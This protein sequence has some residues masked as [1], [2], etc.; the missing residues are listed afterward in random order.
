MNAAVI[1]PEKL[2]RELNELWAQLAAEKEGAEHDVL[3]SCSMTLIVLT[4]GG[5]D[6][7]EVMET[8]GGL[9]P[10]YPCRLILIDIAPGQ[11]RF[12]QSSVRAHCWRPFSGQRQV[13][14][15]QISL[16]AAGGALGDLPPVVRALIVPDLPVVLWCLQMD[17]LAAGEVTP[18]IRTAGK[19][20]VDSHG[21]QPAAAFEQIERLQS[22][23]ILLGDLAWARLTRWRELL[24]QTLACVAASGPVSVDKATVVYAEPEPGTEAFYLAGWLKQAFGSGTACVLAPVKA[25]GAAEDGIVAVTIEG[26]GQTVAAVATGDG[27]V[28]VR[29]GDVMSWA[30]IEARDKA[31]LLGEELGIEGP[32]LVYSRALPQAAAL[33]RRTP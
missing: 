33:A 4:R 23:Q 11:E 26:P 27:G 20:V 8:L 5:S 17:L 21:V 12:L 2:L 6:D 9:M 15:E 13:C 19:I 25:P 3:R 24:A 32:D 16:R 1:R 31:S 22:K 10:L 14:V 29:V 18:L 7:P 28:M 30:T